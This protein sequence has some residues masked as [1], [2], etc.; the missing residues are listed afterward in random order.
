[1][2]LCLASDVTQVHIVPGMVTPG[3]LE[4]CF[5]L[6]SQAKKF[7]SLFVEQVRDNGVNTLQ[8]AVQYGQDLIERPT[9]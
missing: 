3:H 8:Y 6:N 9:T 5:D 7:L 1:M 4:I 2:T